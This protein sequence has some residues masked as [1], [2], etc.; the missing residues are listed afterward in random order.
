MIPKMRKVY[1]KLLEGQ[2]ISREESAYLCSN[3]FLLIEEQMDDLFLDE[4][5]YGQW[6]YTRLLLKN[7]VRAREEK[8][9]VG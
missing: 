8:K 4:N 2:E 3:L 5:V 9:F 1:N 7:L 6:I